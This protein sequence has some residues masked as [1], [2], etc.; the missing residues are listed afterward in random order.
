MNAIAGTSEATLSQG[1]FELAKAWLATQSWFKG[2]PGASLECVGSYRFR[3]DDPDVGL[4]TLL[5]DDGRHRW[6]VA[7][8]DRGTPLA[9]DAGLIGTL[10]DG[11][12]GTRWVYVATYDPAYVA[13]LLRVIY[14][15]DIEDLAHDEEPS[16]I[17]VQGSGRGHRLPFTLVSSRAQPDATVRCEVTTP[18]G[19]RTLRVRLV[20]DWDDAPLAPDGELSGHL[21]AIWRSSGRIAAL[22]TAD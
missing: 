1:R 6:Q 10:G 12:P 5:L 19:P 21:R 3:V 18:T 22:V 13:E 4:Q 9:D 17:R 8:S 15:G 11:L 14:T 2:A 7:L 16:N 20:R